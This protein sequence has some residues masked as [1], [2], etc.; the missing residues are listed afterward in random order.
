ME[1]KM[2]DVVLTA[3]ETARLAALQAMPIRSVEQDAELAALILHA[4]PP[5]RPALTADEVRRREELRFMPTRTAAQQAELDRL[6]M[7]DATASAGLMT[8][9]DPAEILRRDALRAMSPR[10]PDEQ[11][12]LDKLEARPAVMPVVETRPVNPTADAFDV[13]VRMMRSLGAA[14]PIVSQAMKMLANEL[15]GHA[16]TLRRNV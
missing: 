2:V 9:L 14:F 11:A 16:D 6:E 1:A 4:P 12:E 15:E 8:V 7:G 5:L 3:A 10:T 13:M